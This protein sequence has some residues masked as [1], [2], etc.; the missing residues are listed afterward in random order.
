ME[1]ID[2]QM[3]EYI[4]ESGNRIR[5]M[6]KGIK[7]GQVAMSIGESTRMTCNGERESK[8][9]KEYFTETRMKKARSSAGVKYHEILQYL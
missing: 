9:R 8:K 7:G 2:G 6:A 4:T 5:K 3:E 1:Y